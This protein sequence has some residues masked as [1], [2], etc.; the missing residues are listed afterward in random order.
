MTRCRSALAL[1]ALLA[2]WLAPS[3]LARV[4]R[5][6]PG[7]TRRAPTRLWY[8]V[9]LYGASDRLWSQVANVNILSQPSLFAGTDYE[10]NKISFSAQSEHAVILVKEAD[11]TVHTTASLF[12]GF[13]YSEHDW[14]DYTHSCDGG[15]VTKTPASP[16]Y[17]GGQMIASLSPRASSSALRFSLATSLAG[18]DDYSY[19]PIS[20]IVDNK[21][22][23]F[24]EGSTHQTQAVFG[25]YGCFPSAQYKYDIQGKLRFGRS[26]SIRAQCTGYVG[27]SESGQLSTSERY[28]IYFEICPRGG[29]AV[30]PCRAHPIRHPWPTK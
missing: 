5:P 14:V 12:G 6:G 21:S 10:Q 15:D 20:C 9:V 29:R 27:D 2:L 19:T 22:V 30:K 7:A 8:R 28:G 1:S 23:M 24:T 13:S 25:T 17:F 3:A 26:F 11:G 18:T 16:G 4:T